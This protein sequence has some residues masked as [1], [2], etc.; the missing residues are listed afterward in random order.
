[1]AGPR[2][3]D[4]VELPRQVSAMWDAA[5]AE[6]A[7]LREEV[8]RVA[9]LGRAQASLTHARSE[10]EVALMRLGE[11]VFKMVE[12]RELA[13]PAALRRSLSEVKARDIDLLRQQ[14]DIAAILK[15]ADALA[16]RSA[17]RSPPRKKK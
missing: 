1:M 9:E 2:Q 7:R 3:T 12:C 5:K 6:L 16:E 11:Q 13:P 14:S 17:Q 15:E 4:E 8:Q 10:R